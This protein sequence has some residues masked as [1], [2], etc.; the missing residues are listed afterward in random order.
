MAGTRKKL[1]WHLYPTYLVIILLSLLAVGWYST[2]S[3]EKLYLEQTEQ[4]LETKANLTREFLEEHTDEACRK[5][6]EILSARLTIILRDGRVVCDSDEDSQK[7]DN[8]GKRPEILE[9]YAGKRGTSIRHSDT[10]D[11]DMMYVAIPVEL[12]GEIWGVIRTSTPVIPMIDEL[13]AIYFKILVVG[14]IVAVLAAVISFLI[15]RR[16]NKPL[17]QMEKGAELFAKGDL[18]HRLEV[19]TSE[20]MATLAEAM[21]KM[22]AELSDRIKTLKRLE[23]VRRDFVANVSHELKTP[24][25]AIKGFLETLENGAIEDPEDARRF[26]EIMTRHSDRLQAIIEDLLYLSRIE[27]ESEKEEIELTVQRIEPVL[28]A[29]AAACEQKASEHDIKISIQCDKTIDARVNERLLEQAITNLLD[30]AIKY[31]DSGDAVEISCLESSGEI[32]IEVKDQ[33]C[34][35]PIQHQ[36]RIFERFYRVDKA[37]SRALGG[38]GLGLAIVKHIVMAHG[39]S[40]SVVSRPDQGSTFTIHLPV[41]KQLSLL[42]N[43]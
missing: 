27:Q 43:F 10:L 3:I 37:R 41:V 18:D 22:A 35:I 1:I 9:A 32:R 4:Q 12:D 29:A 38:T 2:R 5:F 42:T 8:H 17:A 34:G 11:K 24:I 15:A 36:Q 33:G 26:I 20:E 25:T 28:K 30:N 19:P 16:I 39:G 31:S 40:V 21:N 7:M 14:M 13:Q 23:N 6:G